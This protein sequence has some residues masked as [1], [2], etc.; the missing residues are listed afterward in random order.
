MTIWFCEMVVDCQA[1]WEELKFTD[2]PRVRDCENCGKQVH[3]V[4]TQAE[5]DEAAKRGHCVSFIKTPVEELPEEMKKRLLQLDKNK[6]LDKSRMTASRRT[7]GLPRSNP[8]DKLR[9][10]LDS[11]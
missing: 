9:R 11:M 8:S 1:N 10:F 6:S 7:M 2:N 4:E 3:V 5:L